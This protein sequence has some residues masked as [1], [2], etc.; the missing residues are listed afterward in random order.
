MYVLM[1]WSMLMVS[2]NA[3]ES[4]LV[5][6]AAWMAPQLLRLLQAVLQVPAEYPMLKWGILRRNA[7]STC[8]LACTLSA[9]PA[10]HEAVTGRP[11]DVVLGARAAAA[12]RQVRQEKDMK[13]PS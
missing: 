6:P 12:L 11:G 3:S 7:I 2:N 1:L 8:V 13:R 9:H 10:L 4:R 5:P